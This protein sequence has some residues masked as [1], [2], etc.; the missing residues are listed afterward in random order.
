MNIGSEKINPSEAGSSRSQSH[1]QVS[2]SE[3]LWS[4]VRAPGKCSVALARSRLATRRRP[5]LQ[6]L[7]QPRQSTA[8]VLERFLR[9]FFLVF[10]L[11]TSLISYPSV[12]A[13]IGDPRVDLT[14]LRVVCFITKE[15]H[16]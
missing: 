9:F 10:D 5:E 6:K 8:P 2:R 11:F 13:C 3:S 1:S 15:V 12:H 16:V 7:T 14:S 4:R